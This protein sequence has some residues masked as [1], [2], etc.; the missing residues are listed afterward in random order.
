MPFTKDK[1]SYRY[2]NDV[3]E[4]RPLNPREIEILQAHHDAKIDYHDKT[5][6]HLK[7]TSVGREHPIYKAH[8]A[9]F[10]AH[11]LAKP[12]KRTERTLLS[13]REQTEE[14]DRLS[15][16]AETL[17]HTPVAPWIQALQEENEE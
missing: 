2:A 17:Q 3:E 10:S 1:W 13:Q 11:C 12:G 6:D 14:A 16:E 5:L 8:Q 9:A 4:D 15:R 7:E